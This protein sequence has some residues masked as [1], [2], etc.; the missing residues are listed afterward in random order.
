MEDLLAG[1]RG[2]REQTI[3]RRPP[4]LQEAVEG[5]DEAVVVDAGEAGA[6]SEDQAR[7][8][9]LLR[10]QGLQGDPAPRA[11]IERG[12]ELGLA[13][14]Q[15]PLDG[16][17]LGP[18]ART[19]RRRP[20]SSPLSPPG[21]AELVRD[22]LAGGEEVAHARDEAELLP[23]RVVEGRGMP[24][25]VPA[26]ELRG[27]QP[28]LGSD[29]AVQELLSLP[30]P[31]AVLDLV[32]HGGEVQ[33]VILLRREFAHGQ[34]GEIDLDSNLRQGLGHRGHPRLLLPR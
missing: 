1:W 34:R 21:V 10:G 25:G 6:R 5:V 17:Q 19:E 23:I 31:G 24:A 26:R 11:G 7:I 2:N 28:T 9:E 13:F 16:P 4:T 8:R 30:I 20:L 22:Q 14:L 32:S 33:L 29:H 27:E 3:E 12:H 15:E 18:S